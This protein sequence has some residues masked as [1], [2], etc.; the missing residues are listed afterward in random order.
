MSLIV[1]STFDTLICTNPPLQITIFNETHPTDLYSSI[2]DDFTIGVCGSDPFEKNRGCCVSSL[3]INQTVYP[4]FTFSYYNGID[5]DLFI[6]R[7]A[8]GNGY[9]LLTFLQD[10]LS[11][12]SSTYY[13]LDT[14]VKGIK[15][16][17]EG[18]S[19]FQ[20]EVCQ[21]EFQLFTEFNIS[22]S[23]FGNATIEYRH[24][25]NALQEF[26]W[27][28]YTPS[29]YL[30]PDNKSA[31]DI[32][33]LLCFIISI[34]GFACTT[35]YYVLKYK[36][37]KSPSSIPLILT[38]IAWLLRA[39]MWLGYNYTIF[40]NSYIF[41]V[42]SS[43]LAVIPAT[44]LSVLISTHLLCQIL[45]FR[46]HWYNYLVYATVVLVNLALNSEYYTFQIIGIYNPDL[47]NMMAANAY[48]MLSIWEIFMLIY[49]DLVPLLILLR[50]IKTLAQKKKKLLS[51]DKAILTV[52]VSQ[53]LVAIITMALSYIQNNTEIV[54]S[55]RNMVDMNGIY[56]ILYFIH[57]INILLLFHF[58]KK[59][60]MHSLVKPQQKIEKINPP[61]DTDLDK[62]T[63]ALNKY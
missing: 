55:E 40:T 32:F 18:I 22:D 5:I 38:Q 1:S 37:T 42:Y 52:I 49:D 50:I 8:N 23:I 30:I 59:I 47:Y 3:D 36:T 6:P 29:Y 58:L 34:G 11:W 21:Q 4:S 60:T 27:I 46:I 9:C 43:I 48:R 10:D 33:A 54:G 15:C 56:L 51:K 26:Q 14:C 63:V 20:D 25:D 41:Y 44:L 19:I 17:G 12:Y 57:N 13:L 7:S 35:V 45:N 61:T 31:I 39:I 28:T 16:N 24:F 62:T 2:S 53:F